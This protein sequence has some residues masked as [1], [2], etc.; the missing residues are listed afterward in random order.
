MDYIKLKLQTEL[1]IKLQ[2]YKLEIF[3]QIYKLEIFF[4]TQMTH[5]MVYIIDKFVTKD[6]RALLISPI[7]LKFIWMIIQQ[8]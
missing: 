4:F 2:I 3:L 6:I 7:K 5:F 8:S 1:H